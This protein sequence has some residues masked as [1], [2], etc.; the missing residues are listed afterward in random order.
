[1]IALLARDVSRRTSSTATTTMNVDHDKEEASEHQS[2]WLGHNIIHSP[3][4]VS[5]AKLNWKINNNENLISSLHW[6]TDRSTEIEHEELV[7]QVPRQAQE[8]EDGL[9]G[10]W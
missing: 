4:T 2:A 1:M 10:P 5:S 6:Q 7:V 3:T 8:E 9:G